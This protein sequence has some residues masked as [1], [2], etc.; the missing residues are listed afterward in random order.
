[1]KSVLDELSVIAGKLPAGGCAIWHKRCTGKKG[2]WFCLA[3]LY[4]FYS[5][6]MYCACAADCTERPRFRVPE[7]GG[8]V[9][10]DTIGVDWSIMDLTWRIGGYWVA[11]LFSS[12]GCT[13][14]WHE[15]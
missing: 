13:M 8:K 15:H 14:K 7:P 5:L 10:C 4:L 11:D 6:G 9:V 1:M 2:V 12:H 3:F